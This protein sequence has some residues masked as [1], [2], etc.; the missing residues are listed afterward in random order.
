[1]STLSNAPVRATIAVRDQARAKSFYGDKLGLTLA[2][3]M[4]GALS[5]ECG[6]GTTLDVYPSQ[7]AGTA[8]STVAGF[9]VSDLAAVMAELRGNGI[10]FEEY[11]MPGI[12]TTDGVAETDG[13]R[14]AWFKD[15]DG[16]V[17]SLL[18]RS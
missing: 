5:Y 15:P 16:N 1:M 10:T 18:Q 4:E 13:M 8:K 12:K 3:E 9:E 14:G 2:H 17:I 6:G 11:D 7:F